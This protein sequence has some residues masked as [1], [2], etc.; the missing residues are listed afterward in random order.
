MDADGLTDY[1]R[2]QIAQFQEMDRQE[3][4]RKAQQAQGGTQAL[5]TNQM[6]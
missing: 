5:Q 1:E 2:A 4:L 3:A 6:Q